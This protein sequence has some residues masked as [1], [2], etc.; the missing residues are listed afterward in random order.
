M[1][2][3]FFL[4]SAGLG[5]I[6]GSFLNV[7]ILRYNTGRTL[8]GRSGCLTCG[9]SL[10]WTELIPVFS[11]L[12]LRG[13]CGVCQ[14]KIS[15]QYPLVELA[16]A[17]LFALCA[18]KFFPSWPEMILVWLILSLLIVIT[19]YDLRH[20]IIPEALVYLFDSLALLWA[21]IFGESL[22]FAFLAGLI[23]FSAF[24]ALWYFSH[25]TWMGFGDAKLVIGLG[26]LLGLEA[27]FSALLWAF[28]VGAI[29]GLLLLASTKLKSLP[30]AW[31]RFTMK[32]EVPFAPFLVLGLLLVWLGHFDL[33]NAFLL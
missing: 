26:F 19:V 10:S 21:L 25:G 3:F 33:F 31:P 20:K 18:Y 22:L 2:R 16:T 27:G 17:G 5:L 9:H 28:V 15:W 1:S 8:G 30:F 32:T 29:V 24:W 11:F 4:F 23:F 6:I 12:R 14:A 7:V 13:R